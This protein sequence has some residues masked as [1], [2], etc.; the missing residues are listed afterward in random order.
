MTTTRVAVR[1]RLSIET[2]SLIFQTKWNLIADNNFLV[3]CNVCLKWLGHPMKVLQ[4][5]DVHWAKWNLRQSMLRS[6]IKDR[7]QN[8]NN[9]AR[10]RHWRS[11]PTYCYLTMWPSQKIPNFFSTA[12]KTMKCTEIDIK[13][14][15]FAH[16]LVLRRLKT[17]WSI[18]ALKC[19]AKTAPDP[20]NW[21][22]LQAFAE[23]GNHQFSLAGN[24]V[25]S[26]NTSLWYSLH[27][28]WR[29]LL[30]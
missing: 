15:G 29:I 24:N 20:P 6:I 3:L 30:H 5:V 9:D 28:L 7:A 22:P 13:C 11:V 12:R 21:S 26:L 8:R 25:T 23:N 19:D 1:V 16:S 27:F 14:S 17:D 2:I 18:G 10:V 4:T